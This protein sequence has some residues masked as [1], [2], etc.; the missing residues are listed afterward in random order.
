MAETH[1]LTIGQFSSLS[2]LSVRMLRHYDDNGV[3]NPARVDAG[4]GYRWYA[5]T[6]LQDATTIRQLR[7]VGF[8][9]SAIA[10]LLPARTSPEYTRAL[11]LQRQVLTEEASAAQQRLNHITRLIDQSRG[12]NMPTVTVGE[13]TLPTQTVVALRGTIP[14]YTDE[15]LLWDKFMALL[16][17]QGVPVSSP[18]GVTEHDEGYVER[19]V[20]CSVWMPVAA[21]T[22]VQAPLTIEQQP[23]QRVAVARLVGPYRHI[24]EACEALAAHIQDQG[25]EVTGAMF[26][27]YLNDVRTTPEDELVT[28][29]CLPV[30]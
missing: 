18:P 26:N 3:L 2:R 6:Q 22:P 5:P 13:Q 21:D 28:E 11:V 23:E 19:D 10:A 12:E 17:Q 4:T 30:R 24:H 15:G 16:A 1:L 7:D 14:T 8:S 27:R 25:F 20:D 9:V 29:V